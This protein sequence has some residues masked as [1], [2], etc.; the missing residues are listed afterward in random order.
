MIDITEENL[1]LAYK[2]IRNELKNIVKK[3]LR[4]KK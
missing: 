1:E 4:K 3:L 2:Q